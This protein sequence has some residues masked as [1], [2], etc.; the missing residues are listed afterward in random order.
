[1]ALLKGNEL[2]SAK[3]RNLDLVLRRKSGETKFS[4]IVIGAT[5]QLLEHKS[6]LNTLLS[7][8]LCALISEDKFQFYDLNC[9]KIKSFKAAD[10]HTTAFGDDG[11]VS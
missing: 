6:A 8:E 1:M 7:E 9:N 3:A 5:E 2:D 4:E 10:Q 11:C